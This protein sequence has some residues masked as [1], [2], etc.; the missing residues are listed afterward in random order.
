MIMKDREQKAKALRYCIAKRWFP[1][2]E[3]DVRP[4]RHIS[5]QV[6]LVTDLDVLAFIPDQFRGFRAIVFDCKTGGRE[7]AV[8]RSMWLRGILDLMQSEIGVCIMKKSAIN[9]DHKLVATELDI[10]LLAE[11]EFEIYAEA[12]CSQFNQQVGATGDISVWESLLEIRS[13]YPKLEPTLRYLRSEFWMQKDAAVSCRHVIIKLLAVHG[14]LNPEKEEHQ[15]IACD[16]AAL[17]AHCLAKIVCY[18]FKAYLHP[19]QQVDLDEAV[20]ILIYGG[21]DSYEHRNSLYKLLKQHEESKDKIEE[22]SLP[23]WQRLIKLIR[24]L[25]DAPLDV[26]RTPLILREIGFSRLRREDRSFACTLCKESPQAASFAV[27]I[28]GYLFKASKLPGEFRS[29]VEEEIL[30]FVG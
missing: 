2:I 6:V 15:Y 12:T 23:E 7:S 24:Q 16:M 20:K 21:R 29:S 10:V 5:D 17:F 22:L 1:Q 19:K 3:V 11:D 27:L 30:G 13:K 26:A 25:L 9:A 18:L 14:E 8:N 28:I 4:E